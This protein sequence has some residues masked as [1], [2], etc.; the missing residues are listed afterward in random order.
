MKKILLSA[1][2]VT[3]VLLLSACGGGSKTSSLQ[4]EGDTV[5][6]KYSSLLQIVKHA[7]YTVVTIRNPWDTLKVLHTYLLA[8]RE[9]PLPEHLPEG[10]VVR[11]P[12]QKSVI[13]SSVHCSLWSELDELKGIGGVCGLEYIKLPQIQEGCRNGSIVNVGNSMNP[14]IERIIDLR[15][16][17][18]LL[19]PFEN[20]GGYGRVGKL[21]I[22]II[23]CADYMETS[24]LGRAEWMRLY[25]LLLGKEAQADSLFAGIE[26][27][28]LTLTQQ[29]K[30]QNLKRPTVISEMKNSSAWYIPGGNSTMG[31]LYQDA[32]A[33]YVFASLSNS[34]SVPL[35]FE[36]VFDRGGNA[37][38]WLIKYNQPQDKTYSELE[39][40]YAPYARFKAFQDRKVYGCNTNHVPFYEE[41]PFHPELLLKDLIKIFHPELLPD[42]DLKY[43]SNLAE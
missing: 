38:I 37:D 11:T 14:D 25:G 5:R 39:R 40:D 15:P 29:V 6:M 18:I 4:A 12:L 42:Y 17:A 2:I 36:T 27:E 13:Y 31:R 7:D 34:G 26:K 16:D 33:D 8:D 32:G 22:P 10:T 19:S 35:A 3:W 28:Y 20:S 30:S 1:Y 24:A 43:F 41:S 9:K 23:E 21:N